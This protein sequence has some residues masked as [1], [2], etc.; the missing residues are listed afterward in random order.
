MNCTVQA[1]INYRNLELIRAFV[2]LQAQFLLVM[3]SFMALH[4]L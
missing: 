4:H 1:Y 3:Y 2:D